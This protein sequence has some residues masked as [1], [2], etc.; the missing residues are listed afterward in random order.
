[1]NA[2]L[3]T[4]W[5]RSYTAYF[6]FCTSNEIPQDTAAII[7]MGPITAKNRRILSRRSSAVSRRANVST[8]ANQY[9]S[10]SVSCVIKPP[11]LMCRLLLMVRRK[12]PAFCFQPTKP[13]FKKHLL[14]I[15]YPDTASARWHKPTECISSSHTNT[16]SIYPAA[17]SVQT[18]KRRWQQTTVARTPSAALPAE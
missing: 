5:S 4:D 16:S 11:L 9:F 10:E 6:R 3:C 1:M 7:T 8:V 14:H 17:V 2:R 12:Q 13:S 15:I 18:G